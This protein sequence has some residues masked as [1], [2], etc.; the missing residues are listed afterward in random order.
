MSEFDCDYHY[1]KPSGKWKYS[2]EGM[3]PT[4]ELLELTPEV[5]F[6]V[7]HDTIFKA[8]NNSM[9]GITSDGKY[10]VVVVIPRPNCNCKYAYPRMIPNV[11]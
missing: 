8:N 2:G 1:F 5:W 7:D 4:A 6:N 11:Q 9:P 3:F 10:L